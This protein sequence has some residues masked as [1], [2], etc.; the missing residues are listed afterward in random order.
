MSDTS[1]S[2]E[3]RRAVVAAEQDGWRLD[4]FLSVALGD[5]SR[6]RIQQLLEAGAVTHTRK[7]IRDGNFRVKPGEAYT[8]SVPEA[9]PAEPLGQ[10]IPLDV[11]Y[12]DDDL[13]VIDKP[14]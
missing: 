7:T 4:R 10:D 9:A 6:S 3:P 2:D 12:E 1:S 14:A 11:V 8:V 13:I 5:I